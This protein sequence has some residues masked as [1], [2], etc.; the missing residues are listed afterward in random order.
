[1]VARD[2]LLES[3]RED[4]E[5]TPEEK[6]T[7]L[8]FGKRDSHV[9]VHTRERGVARRLLAHPEGDIQFL[10]TYVDG[11][12]R[13]IDPSEDDLQGDVTGVCISLPLGVLKIQKNARSN[14]QH[15][16]VVS[17]RVFGA[18]EDDSE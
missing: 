17:E 3:V 2:D 16:A 11:T 6:E 15:A 1:M 4:P 10:N 8:Y 9:T 12:A 13:Q 14:S 5:L 18:R 7:T